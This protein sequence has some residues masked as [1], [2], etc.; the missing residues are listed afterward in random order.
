MNEQVNVEEDNRK[1][2]IE[3]YRP[4]RLDEIIYQDDVV[5]SFKGI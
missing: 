2:W 3:K 5:R 1:P 4:K